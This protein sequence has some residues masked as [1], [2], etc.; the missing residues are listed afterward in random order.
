MI[1]KEK[2]LL[3]FSNDMSLWYLSRFSYC[4]IFSKNNIKQQRI[5][6]KLY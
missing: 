4:L 5:D 3:P 2:E 6:I 1:E